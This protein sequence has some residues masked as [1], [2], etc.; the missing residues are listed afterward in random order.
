[1]REGT[2]VAF[3]II[4]VFASE[5]VTSDILIITVFASERVRYK[6]MFIEERRR[7]NEGKA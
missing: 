3:L 7:Q 5:R 4:T 2:P 6:L 1:M